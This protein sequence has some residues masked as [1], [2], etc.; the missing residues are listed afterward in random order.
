MLNIE[1]FDCL[2]SRWF[3]VSESLFNRFPVFV[4]AHALEVF[5]VFGDEVGGELGDLFGGEADLSSLGG[6]GHSVEAFGSG[7]G[8]FVDDFENGEGGFS[9]FPVAV[10][11]RSSG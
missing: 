11:E 1:C 6:H 8:A 5:G 3:L 10:I 9:V 4:E 2:D 7:R